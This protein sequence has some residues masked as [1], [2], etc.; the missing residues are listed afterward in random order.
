MMLKRI[1]CWIIVCALW[2]CSLPDPVESDV[3][4]A[5]EESIWNQP[6][7]LWVGSEKLY[8]AN[9]NY[10]ITQGGVVYEDGYVSVLDRDD[11]VEIARWELPLKNPVLIEA[12]G[13]DLWVLCMGD[14]RRD[15]QGLFYVA[16]PGGLVRL[17]GAVGEL[18]TEPEI[19]GFALEPDGSPGSWAWL[20]ER[21]EIVL[22]SSIDPELYV[23]GLENLDW[24]RG[25]T[26]PVEQPEA[27]GDETLSVIAHPD[28]HVGILSFARNS[29]R[30]V[31][32]EHFE[33]VDGTEEVLLAVGD[34]LEGPLSG[35][36]V[37]EDDV[38]VAYVVLSLSNSLARWV[39]GAPEATEPRFRQLG[40]T[41]NQIVANDSMF[42]IVESGDNVLS[43]HP[44][45]GGDPVK[46]VFPVGTNPYSAAVSVDGTVVYVTGLLSNSI[47]EVDVESAQILGQ[48]PVKP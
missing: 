11:L 43:M 15:A 14:I 22:G 13:E 16:E 4:N 7:G 18:Q 17:K 41:P 26:N 38:P 47:F 27:K 39:P 31:D 40:L 36:F 33:N 9:A 5:P 25:T 3:N 48:G 2:G 21:R 12:D 10:Y 24:T 45:A 6:Q 44:R 29:A 37:L 34:E 32:G 19:Q 20:P 30:L 46:V 1:F 8:V 42:F 28:G 23:F 35:V